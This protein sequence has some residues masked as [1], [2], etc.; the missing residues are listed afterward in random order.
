[1][2]T[3]TQLLEDI[4][5]ELTTLPSKMNFKIGEAAQILGVKTHVLRY[6]E[7]EFSLLKPKKFINN[8]RLYIQKDMEILFLIKKL[9]H[10]YSFSI[11][12]VR[13]NLSKYYNSLKKEQSFSKI[14]DV[15]QER[16]TE[17]KR[18]IQSIVEDIQCF[19]EDLTKEISL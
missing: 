5:S 8:Q 19:K 4:Q 13:K 18:K 2:V 14:K 10:E 6:W 9:L 12:G 15:N 3:D 11:K 7:D 17:I 1:M 16:N